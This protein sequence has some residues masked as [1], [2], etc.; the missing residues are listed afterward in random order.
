M[1]DSQTVL[2]LLRME[3]VYATDD[4]EVGV[5]TVV[6]QTAMIP[7]SPKRVGPSCASYPRINLDTSEVPRS[8]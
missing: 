5:A 2:K 4:T 7:P 6:G 3:E 1:A 8:I